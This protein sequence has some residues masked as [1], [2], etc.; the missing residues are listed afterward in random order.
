LLPLE[1][2]PRGMM[3][4]GIFLF[5]GASMA[6][7]AAVTLLWPGTILDRTWV[8]NPT[9]HLRLEPLGKPAGILF[10]ILAATLARA[11][12]GWLRRRKWGWWLAVII[13]GTQV[14]GDAV[15]MVLGE[16]W[17]GAL[18]AVIAGAVLFYLLR[19]KTRAAFE[20]GNSPRSE[21]S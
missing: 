16:F 21:G 19:P 20:Q 15:N 3:A 4:M 18:G 10:L 17:R 2:S 6:A 9:A 8:L 5:F 1:K 14:A 11:G 12:A 7:L 13:I